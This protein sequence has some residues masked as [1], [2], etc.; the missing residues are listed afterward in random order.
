[1][2]LS[3]NSTFEIKRSLRY[4]GS[5]FIDEKSLLKCINRYMVLIKGGL[6]INSLEDFYNTD[7]TFVDKL[8]DLEALIV[9]K[10][11]FTELDGLVKVG[12]DFVVLVDDEITRNKKEEL[13]TIGKVVEVPEKNYSNGSLVYTGSYLF[14]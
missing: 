6:F 5:F 1:M 13:L 2:G 11:M 9:L 3:T 12:S 4:L 10:I 8:A 14:K 7:T